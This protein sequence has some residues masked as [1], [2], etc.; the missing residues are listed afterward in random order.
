MFLFNVLG[1][2]LYLIA[3]TNGRTAH[4]D[5]EFQLL[6][7]MFT[8]TSVVVSSIGSLLTFGAKNLAMSIFRPGSLAV[9]KGNIVSVKV[10]ASV[11]KLLSTTHKL[12]ATSEG[13]KKVV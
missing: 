3:I 9:L 7:R 6:G 2:L 4:D 13:K 12:L 8:L 11:L 1:L 5:Q 10:D